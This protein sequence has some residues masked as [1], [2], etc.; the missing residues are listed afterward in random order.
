[1]VILFVWFVFLFKIVIWI[2]IS[3]LFCDIGYVCIILNFYYKIWLVCWIKMLD[4]FCL[5]LMY[6]YIRYVNGYIVLYVVYL[7]FK[8]VLGIKILI[9]NLICDKICDFIFVFVCFVYWIVNLF[10]WWSV[11]LS[12]IGFWFNFKLMFDFLLYV[13]F[14][15]KKIFFFVYIFLCIIK[16]VIILLLICF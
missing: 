13:I 11:G 14:N 9:I 6:V 10:I 5:L 2:D 8:N 4:L 16:F 15:W 1:M 7:N 3:I 12:V